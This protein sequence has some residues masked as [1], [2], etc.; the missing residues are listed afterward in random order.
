M[1]TIRPVAAVPPAPSVE[2][3]RPIEPQVS[4]ARDERQNLDPAVSVEIG[5]NASSSSSRA[6]SDERRGFERD[7]ETKAVVYRVTDTFSGDVVIQIPN[8]IVLKARAY[9]RQPNPPAGERIE[10]VA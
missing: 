10:K 7:L 5:T 4:T 2:A 1:D 9:A 3:S 6:S 8:E